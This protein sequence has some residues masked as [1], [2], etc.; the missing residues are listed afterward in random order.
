MCFWLSI[1]LCLEMQFVTKLWHSLLNHPF[2]WCTCELVKIEGWI[3]SYVKRKVF[4]ELYA[5]LNNWVQ[6]TIHYLVESPLAAITWSNRFY[7]SSVSHA[8][9]EDSSLQ[10]CFSSFR[11]VSICSHTALLRSSHSISVMLRSGLCN[12]FS[13]SAILLM[14]LGSLSYCIAYFWPRFCCPTDGLTLDSGVLWNTMAA[15]WAQIIIPPKPCLTV[16]WGVCT[17]AQLASN[18]CAPLHYD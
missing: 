8:V 9:V 18:K 1:L 5:V 10:H 4:I 2:I 17:D 16:V 15:K 6:I 13:I 11:F 14:C 3:S 7:T 12:I